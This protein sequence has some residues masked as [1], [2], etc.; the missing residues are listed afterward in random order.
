L[1]DEL[2]SNKKVVVITPISNEIFN[3]EDSR[4]SLIKS[5]DYFFDFEFKVPDFTEFQKKIFRNEFQEDLWMKQLNSFFQSLFQDFETM[6][7]RLLKMILR[8]AERNY[9]NQK[10]E[11]REPDFRITIMIESSKYFKVNRKKGL[12]FHQS[13]KKSGLIDANNIFKSFLFAISENK[14]TI[15]HKNS[16]GS[17]IYYS[18]DKK[19]KFINNKK[20]GKEEPWFIGT[21]PF[22]KEGAY[23]LRSF[24]LN[25]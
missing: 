4:D 8:K 20:P 19:F 15:K 3:Q 1:R 2:K 9:I 6:T 10:K 18:I 12:Y 23:Y 5:I 24:Y 22:E 17:E 7:P 25:Y 16:D 21:N 13:F 11:G 14:E